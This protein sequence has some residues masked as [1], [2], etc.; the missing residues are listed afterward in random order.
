MANTHNT[1]I[2][3]EDS[4]IKNVWKPHLNFG[5]RKCVRKRCLLESGNGVTIHQTGLNLKTTKFVTI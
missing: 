1:H 4:L 3:C 2:V 5:E